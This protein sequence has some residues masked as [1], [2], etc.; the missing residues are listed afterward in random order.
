MIRKMYLFKNKISTQILKKYYNSVPQIKRN[1]RA[2][3]LLN[4][5]P[6]NGFH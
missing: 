2:V 5:G 1:I 3:S 4:C 6:N